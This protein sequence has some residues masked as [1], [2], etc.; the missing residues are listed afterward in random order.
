MTNLKVIKIHSPINH[1][2]LKYDKVDHSLIDP[3]LYSSIIIDHNQRLID[4]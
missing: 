4:D 1:C 2:C 3:N